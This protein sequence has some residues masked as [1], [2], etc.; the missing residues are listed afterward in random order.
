MVKLFKRKS[1][2]QTENFK[3]DASI[4]LKDLSIE[5]YAHVAY[6]FQVSMLRFE[7]MLKESLLEGYITSSTLEKISREFD[8]SSIRNLEI[9]KISSVESL[10]EVEL[11]EKL[12]KKEIKETIEEKPSITKPQ[13]PTAQAPIS[14]AQTAPSST[15]TP[16]IPSAPSL[17]APR[18]ST[19]PQ[20]SQPSSSSPKITFSFPESPSDSKPDPLLPQAPEKSIMT[21]SIPKISFPSSTTAAP[22]QGSSPIEQYARRRE[23][24]RATGI[25]ILRKQ[26]LSE[27]K[28]IRSVV[29]EEEK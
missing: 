25:A 15:M 5:E 26:M 29:S 19:T 3:F 21:P 17:G 8:I 20:Q 18:T 4:K 27:L 10:F 9:P 24:D 14:S 23:E 7:R 12:V 6:A 22:S 1:G 13:I 2:A 11:P 16:S 28:K